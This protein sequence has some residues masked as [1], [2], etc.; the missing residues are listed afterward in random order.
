MTK[1]IFPSHDKP[2]SP[3]ELLKRWLK[4]HG[5][6]GA[7]FITRILK[8]EHMT[9]ERFTPQSVRLIVKHTV[10]KAV[11]SLDLTAT[12]RSQVNA[13]VTGVASSQGCNRG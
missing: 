11:L 12:A 8:N 5:S 7:L 2:V 1:A 6:Y 10:A 4:I 13:S 9:D 3:T